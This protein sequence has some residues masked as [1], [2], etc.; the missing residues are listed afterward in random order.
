LHHAGRSDLL[1]ELFPGLVAE[2]KGTCADA[3]PEG[4][5]LVTFPLHPK[6]HHVC[7]EEGAHWVKDLWV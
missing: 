6:P 2:Y 1:Q 3:L 7:E 5:R 4:V